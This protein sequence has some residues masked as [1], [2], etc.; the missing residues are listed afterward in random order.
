MAL[1]AHEQ[2]LI[3][4]LEKQFKE[5]G[6][7]FAKAM[8]QVPARNRSA[9]RIV[10]G[11]ATAVAGFLHPLLGAAVQGPVPNIL[12]GVLGFAVM[13]VGAHLAIRHTSV[14]KNEAPAPTSENTESAERAKA[15]T[16]RR[17]FR[18]AF[19]DWALWGLFWWV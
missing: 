6:P 13:V 8:E 12:V 15:D 17:P 7:R 11:A 19:G 14:T 10:T 3:E 2:N 9:L 16:D 5:E 4:Q 1:S 18:D